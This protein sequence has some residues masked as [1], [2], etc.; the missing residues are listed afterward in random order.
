M[1]TLR[2][3]FINSRKQLDEVSYPI[4]LTEAYQQTQIYI[5]SLCNLHNITRKN[6]I[7]NKI[8]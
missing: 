1:K 5:D 2:I 7:F 8:I 6:I 3:I 4:D